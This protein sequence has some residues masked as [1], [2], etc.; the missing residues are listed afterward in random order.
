MGGGLDKETRWRWGKL[1]R[2]KRS[3]QLRCNVSW[4]VNVCCSQKG[5]AR[6]RTSA[7][8]R[9]NAC[10]PLRES[11]SIRPQQAAG[12][13]RRGCSQDHEVHLNGLF[14]NYLV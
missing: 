9:A 1:A 2:S 3:L 13:L 7:P 6:W 8:A 12:L 4:R 10:V 11:V 5:Q 14:N